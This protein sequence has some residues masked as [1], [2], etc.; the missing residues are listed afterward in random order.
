M[1]IKTDSWHYR[2]ICWS[3]NSSLPAEVQTPHPSIC[4]Y[5]WQLVFCLITAPATYFANNTSTK[6]S[7]LIVAVIC[8]Y[9][10]IQLGILQFLLMF[11]VVILVF[12]VFC[13][14]IWS[15]FFRGTTKQWDE[16]SH[17]ITYEYLKAKAS[18]TCPL[19]EF[20]KE[21]E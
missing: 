15:L 21:D 10:L 13:G 14:I 12:V 17:S 7:W 8:L 19:I 2:L 3:L 1:K 6:V 11:G 18:K 4:R 16:E 5:F 9:Y 20:E